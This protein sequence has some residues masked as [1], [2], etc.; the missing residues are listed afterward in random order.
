M[1]SQ[2]RQPAT[3]DSKVTA[4]LDWLALAHGRQGSDDA[5]QLLAHLILL[6]E[7]AIP[8]AQR[9][10]ILDLVY[11]E[12]ERMVFSEI[13]KLLEVSLPVTRKTRQRV[14]LLQD[15]LEAL[16]QEYFNSLAELFDP[17]GNGASLAPQTTLAMIAQCLSWHIRISHLIAAPHS[18][19]IWQ[20]MHS[21]FS[22]GRRLGIDNLAPARDMPTLQAIYTSTLLT[23]IAQPASFSARELEF[24]VALTE[25][26]LM[27]VEISEAPPADSCCL[28]WVDLERDFPAHALVRR[29]PPGSIPILFLSGDGAAHKSRELLS[30]L[31]KGTPA[32]S[33]GLPEFANTRAGQGVLRRLKNLWGHPTKRKFPRRRQSY[34]V[35]LCFGL[36]QLWHLIRE[37]GVANEASEWMVTNESPDGYALMHMSGQTS[38]TR[39]GDIV[40]VQSMGERSE[41]ESPWH[42]CIVRW[43][44]SENPEHVELG[45]QQLASHAIAAELARPLELDSKHIAALI[46]P[47][48]PPF[49]PHAEV[50]V[51]TGMLPVDARKFLLLIE[52]ENLEIREVRPTQLTEQT[53]SI[54]IF[55]VEADET[56]ER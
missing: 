27:P 18:I 9:I 11:R 24:I 56:S 46:L 31:E 54:E 44:L 15:L 32:A 26:G 35:K 7:A 13:P 47:E 39:V 53:T 36:D 28:F 45:L 55:S 25:N 49:R 4:I 38:N 50:V 12:I 1:I 42:V 3:S 20:K 10:K 34:R 17:Q 6:R 30:A 5:E 23:A 8:T 22:S 33:L 41:K 16:S 52:K 19:G 51:Q 21:A 40:A 48:M 43:A 29:L 37:P 2:A 14:R